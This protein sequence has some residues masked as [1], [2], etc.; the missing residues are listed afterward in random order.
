MDGGRERRRDD[1]IVGVFGQVPSAARSPAYD[2]CPASVGPAAGTPRVRG[3][4]SIGGRSRLRGCKQAAAQGRLTSR[5]AGRRAPPTQAARHA[6][7]AK[8][9]ARHGASAAC[10]GEDRG[11][12][13]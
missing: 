8:V 2:R 10:S 12:G 6:A 5:L 1:G 7:S 11:R 9:P 13:V 4:V 3:R